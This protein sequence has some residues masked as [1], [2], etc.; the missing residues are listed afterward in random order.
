MSETETESILTQIDTRLSALGAVAKSLKKPSTVS[1]AERQSLST[2]VTKAAA[3]LRALR[4]GA[5]GA[6]EA[7][8][9]VTTALA[10]A[11]RVLGL[12]DA[13]QPGS[14]S[15]HGASGAASVGGQGRRSGGGMNSQ[16]RPP[17][18]IGS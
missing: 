5:E 3:E 11:D 14:A 16:Q 10:E 2:K 12:V 9:P 17:D 18:R 13:A 15:K 1:F 8:E 6:G 7:S 4:E